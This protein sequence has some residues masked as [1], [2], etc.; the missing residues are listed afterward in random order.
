[1][2]FIL[3]AIKKSEHARKQAKEPDVFSLQN[4]DQSRSFEDKGRNRLLLFLTSIIFVAVI[5]WWLWP[6]LATQLSDLGYLSTPGSLNTS[7]DKSTEKGLK[8]TFNKVISSVRP[9]REKGKV[10]LATAPEAEVAE[11]EDFIYNDESVLPPRHLIKE[12]WELPADYQSTIPNMEFSFHVF[13]K[14]PAK[15]TIIINGRRLREGQMI[16]S[17]LKL[18]VITSTGIILFYKDRF[19]HVD[20]VEKW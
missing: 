14:N 10:N 5:G 20:V 16:A 15:R 3:D 4:Q 11:K 9:E 6:K 2:S 13:S 19:F 7:G 12:L 1:M 17:N 18:R 8:S